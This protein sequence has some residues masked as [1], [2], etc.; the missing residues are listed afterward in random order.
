M[1]DETATNG[2]YSFSST[3]LADFGNP[4]KPTSSDD[5]MLLIDGKEDPKIPTM[6]EVSTHFAVPTEVIA[7]LVNKRI[8][9]TERKGVSHD[10]LINDGLYYLYEAEQ[11]LLELKKKG[12]WINNDNQPA[13]RAF[14]LAYVYNHLRRDLAPHFRN[15]TT[16]LDGET[17]D[18]E[19]N[20]KPIDTISS[21]DSYSGDTEHV[22]IVNTLLSECLKL[23]ADSFTKRE[24]LVFI[25]VMNGKTY[26]QIAEESENLTAEQLK[27]AMKNVVSKLRIYLGID[28]DLPFALFSDRSASNLPPVV[29]QMISRSRKIQYDRYYHLK[30]QEQINAARNARRNKDKI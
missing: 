8:G 16:S 23:A 25:G 19:D 5:L 11:L 7:S 4:D 21:V 1:K 14:L 24:K 27:D 20:A 10:E 26:A 2:P 22:A 12:E 29:Q 30:H 6:P 18:D 28:T 13:E 9:D 15:R 3:E 17:N